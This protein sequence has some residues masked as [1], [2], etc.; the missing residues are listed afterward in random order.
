MEWGSVDIFF[1]LSFITILIF[2]GS[3][4]IQKGSR[5]ENVHRNMREDNDLLIPPNIRI[6]KQI[7]FPYLQR[8]R[9]SLHQTFGHSRCQMKSK[10][11]ELVP[12]N[13]KITL[14]KCV[15]Q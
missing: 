11:N 4:S 3:F 15:L 9:A 14:F 2:C 13:G 8:T 12:F 5:R 10:S 1:F 7:E 6:H